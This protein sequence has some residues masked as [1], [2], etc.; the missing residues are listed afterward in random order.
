MIYNV[1]KPAGWS[2][3]DVVKK[4]RNITKEKKVGHGGTLDPFAEG[5]LIIGTGKDTKTLQQ[6]TNTDKS[7]K[8]VLKLGELT[9][10]LDKEGTITKIKPVPDLNAEEIATVLNSF[11]G[12]QTQIP[13]MY[14]AKKIKGKRL[15]LLARQN[16]EI[17]RE[18]VSINI[19]SIR[20]I[21]FNNSEIKF[22]A[23]VSKGTYI[24]VLGQD[25]ALKL[26][27]VGHLISLIRTKVGDFNYKNSQSIQNFQEKWKLTT[28]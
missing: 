5:V 18:P 7:Y 24:R 2:S 13:P 28:I 19:Y 4:I 17:P 15:Y 23:I 10:T 20:L 12:L 3:F 25:I 26:G 22:S 9:D 21:D 11:R 1:Y 16:L 14:S 6:Y 27:T 8:A